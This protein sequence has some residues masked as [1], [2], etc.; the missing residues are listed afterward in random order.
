MD[1]SKLQNILNKKKAERAR[2]DIK[3]MTPKKGTSRFVLLP[4]WNP[5]DRE[6]FW[7][8]YGEHWCK[9]LGKANAK[10]QPQIVAKVICNN[11]TFGTPCPICEALSEA[12]SNCVNDEQK[13]AIVSNFGSVQRYL[14]NVLALDSETPNEPLILMIGGRGFDQLVEQVGKW[15]NQVFDAVN[16]QVFSIT[17][18]GEGFDTTYVVSINP[19]TYPMPAGVKEKIHD[20]DAYCHSTTPA[21]VG[22]GLQTFARLGVNVS[23]IA[24]SYVPESHQIAT[25]PKPAVENAQTVVSQPVVA[26][27][28]PTQ[29]VKAAHVQPV[30]E[31]KMPSIADDLDSMLASL[32]T[33]NTID[34]ADLP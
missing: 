33:P 14:V 34:P 22:K 18:T 27:I 2:N 29:E 11:K 10:G 24:S 3:V 26:P 30:A 4:G 20:L 6:T 31:P 12:V 17:R 25:Q 9:D 16:P 7:H 5:A 1:L 21:E 13:K 23:A 8:D 32:N 15:S 19:E 28:A